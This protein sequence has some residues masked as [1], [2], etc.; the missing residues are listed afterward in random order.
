MEG[1]VIFSVSVITNISIHISYTKFSTT[2]SK[3]KFEYRNKKGQIKMCSIMLLLADGQVS[4]TELLS[5]VGMHQNDNKN[6]NTNP[7]N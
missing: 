3:Y 7:V 1:G 6:Y 5:H 2:L 4:V